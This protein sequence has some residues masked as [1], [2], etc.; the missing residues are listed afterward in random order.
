MQDHGTILSTLSEHLRQRTRCVQTNAAHADNPRENSDG[1]FV[2]YWMASAMR[3]DENPALDTA[4]SI[5]QELDLPLLVYQGLSQRYPF[6]SDRHHTFIMQGVAELQS[7]F[8]SAGISYA[9]HLQRPGDDEN[10]LGQLATQAAVVIAE[11]MPVDPQRRFLAALKRSCDTTI[12]VVDTACVVPMQMV[13]KAHTRAFKFRDKTKRLYQELLTK[14]WPSCDFE[15]RRFDRD[16]LPFEPVDFT[17]QSIADA[18]AQCQ[19]DHAIGP[20]ADTRGGSDAGYRR[21]NVFKSKGLSTYHRKRNNPLTDGASRMS[22]YLHYGMVS[23]LRI[24]REAAHIDNPGSEKY[25]DELLIWRELA[26]G[27]CFYRPDHH[28][29]SAIGDWAIETLKQHADDPR[30]EVFSWEQ[31]ARA[32]TGDRLWDAAQQS[33]LRQGELHNNVRMTWG[34]AFLQW[35]RSPR[36]ALQMMI[37]L[38]HRY[39]LDG[40]DPSSYGGLLWCLGQFDRPFEPEAAVTG[41]VRR[42]SLADHADRLDVQ[43]YEKKVSTVRFPSPPRVAVVGAGLSGSFAARTL[44]DHG[45]EVT[46]F[47]KSRGVGGRMATRRVDDVPTFDHGAQYFTC[48]DPRFKRYVDSWKMQGRVQPW[49]DPSQ[50]IVVLEK[51]EIKSESKSVQRHVAVPGMKAICQHLSDCIPLKTGVRIASIVRPPQSETGWVLHDDQGDD[52]GTFDNVILALPAEQAAE[53]I[54][55]NPTLDRLS[56]QLKQV[57]MNPCWAMMLTLEQPMDVDWVGAF[58]HGSPIRWIARN[59]TKPKRP[60]DREYLV[61]HA[62]SDWTAQRWDVS[63][64]EIC[65]QLVRAF[66]ESTGVDVTRNHRVVNR[67]AHRW[68]YSIADAD[69]ASPTERC[70]FTSDRSVI[71][72]G[73]WAGGSRVEGAMISGM[74]AAGVL[75]GGVQPQPLSVDSTVNQTLLF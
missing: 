18:V 45:L 13:G 27:F 66:V 47:E 46:L 60:N 41:T 75:M 31:L 11:D 74:S 20:V 33:L 9:F 40:R 59:G 6:A 49:P 1:Q 61:I 55:D 64:D 30:A 67:I 72:C 48:R 3:V 53:I 12:L 38:N 37:D 69:N 22:A 17:T 42:R 24:A 44:A 21:W 65:E 39:A 8:E 5:A 28:R 4:K 19:I 62:D 15:V 63:P 35:T 68:K 58:V 50:R 23:P 70:Y 7:Q 16:R 32:K 2:L 56:Q 52:C 54:G 25:L 43:A 29:I 36:E 34:K 14:Q 73:D 51:G 26:Y 10:Y 71:A 57:K